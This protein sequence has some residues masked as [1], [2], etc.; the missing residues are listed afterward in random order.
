VTL[1]VPL[2]PGNPDQQYTPQATAAGT[3]VFTTK[4]KLRGHRR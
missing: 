3:K 2:G 4:V 1:R